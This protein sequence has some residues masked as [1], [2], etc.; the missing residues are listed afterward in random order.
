[1]LITAFAYLFQGVVSF[2]LWLGFVIVA[3]L[4]EVHVQRLPAADSLSYFW[5]L[6]LFIVVTHCSFLEDD[7]TE[8]SIGLKCKFLSGSVMQDQ[9]RH[10]T[11]GT[12]RQLSP[13]K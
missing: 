9:L 8:M 4:E 1:M 3:F 6:W 13:I 12:G 2:L 5:P 10:S 11:C 7:Y